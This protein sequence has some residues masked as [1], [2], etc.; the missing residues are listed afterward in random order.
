MVTLWTLP[1]SSLELVSVETVSVSQEKEIFGPETKGRKWAVGNRACLP[2]T[3]ALCE[4]PPTGAQIA[5]L[6][7]KSHR[8]RSD[9]WSNEDSNHGPRGFIDGATGSAV[10]GDLVPA[11][12]GARHRTRVAKSCGA[13]VG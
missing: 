3:R 10:F 1:L 8:L 2:E 5:G 9:W 7:G 4:K 6:S 13:L 11:L 12:R